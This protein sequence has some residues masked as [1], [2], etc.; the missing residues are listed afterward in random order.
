MHM[1]NLEQIQPRFREISRASNRQTDKYLSTYLPEL[2]IELK[3][4]KKM[5]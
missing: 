4:K 5:E 1:Q 3:L 2:V